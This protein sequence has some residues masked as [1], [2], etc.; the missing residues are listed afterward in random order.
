MWVCIAMEGKMILIFLI[1]LWATFLLTRL[2]VQ[3]FLSPIRH[4]KSKILTHFLS[5][6]LGFDI[7][8][9]HFGVLILVISLLSFL[10]F[11]SNTIA[12]I[13]LGI[14][15]SLLLDQFYIFFVKDINHFYFSLEGWILSII[16][17]LILSIIL[18]K[19]L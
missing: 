17:H 5:R 16:P 4:P 8:H 13:L 3:T 15:T 10:F 9:F 19:F 12:L 2:Y 14:G 1:S 7:H 6:K 11:S 18:I